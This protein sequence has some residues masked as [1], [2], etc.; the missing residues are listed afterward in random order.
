MNRLLAR[1]ELADLSEKVI[2]GERLS[3][4]D[5]LRLYEAKD[6]LA[7]GALADHVN[8]GRNGDRVY[9]VQNRHINPTNIC[10]V[11]CNF[12]SFRRDGHESDAY[13]WSVDQIVEREHL[14]KAESIHGRRH[15]RFDVHGVI[16]SFRNRVHYRF[17][18]PTDPA[19]SYV[20]ATSSSK[21]RLIAASASGEMSPSVR[22]AYDFTFAALIERTSSSCALTFAG[23]GASSSPTRKAASTPKK[24][25]SPS[26]ST[27]SRTY[28]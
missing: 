26:N 4:E 14:T 5:G 28:R 16:T 1:S 18:Q 7:L 15:G 11:H 2:A 25:A 23:I 9:F 19:C 22:A 24:S 10:A 6:L 20:C 3:L 13:L 17:G 8:R 27:R 21:N 12:C